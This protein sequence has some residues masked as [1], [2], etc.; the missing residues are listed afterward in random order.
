ME[1]QFW[2]VHEE[3]TLNDDPITA[4]LEVLSAVD[5]DYEALIDLNLHWHVLSSN[6]LREMNV[7]VYLNRYV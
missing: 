5:P 6:V 3:T 1:I 4:M 2:E 7:G